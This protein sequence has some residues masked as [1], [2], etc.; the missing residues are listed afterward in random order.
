MIRLAALALLLASA[1]PAQTPRLAFRDAFVPLGARG[2]VPDT[3]AMERA[4]LPSGDAV[5]LGPVLLGL[6]PGSLTDASV[7]FDPFTAAPGISLTMTGP[8]GEAFA[9]LT[10]ARTGQPIAVVL[11]GRVLTAPTVNGAIPNGRVQITGQFTRSEA[12]SIASAIREATQAGDARAALLRRLRAGVDLSRPDSAVVAMR[13]AAGAADW[14]TVARI[15]HPDAQRALRDDAEGELTLS[16]GS[17]LSLDRRGPPPRPV[18]ATPPKPNDP[19]GV[20]IRDVLEQDAP[21]TRW[22]DFSDEQATAL[23]FAAAGGPRPSP[24]RSAVVGTVLDGETAYVVLDAAEATAFG[25]AGIS[26]AVVVE[27]RRVGGQWRVL[28]PASGW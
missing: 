1:A 27:A 23:I 14:L 3:A 17:V 19:P 2:A 24:E 18:G 6:G 13:R 8:A 21:G 16:G 15:L 12:E 20:S 9:R 22:T 5:Y 28:L 26:E 4:A 25:E 11:D 10:E 7:S